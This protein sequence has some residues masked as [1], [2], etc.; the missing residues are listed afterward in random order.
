ME[1]SEWLRQTDPGE[2][3]RVASLCNTTA[4]YFYQIA[5]GHRLASPQLAALIE[6]ATN[7]AVTARKLRPDLAAIF[8]EDNEAA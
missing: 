3:E 6:S 4:D 7:G 8:G 1:M 5:G 2:R